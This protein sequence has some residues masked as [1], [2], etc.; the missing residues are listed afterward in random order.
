MRYLLRS[1][2]T[3]AAVDASLSPDA[4]QRLY[5]AAAGL[6]RLLGEANGGPIWKDLPDVVEAVG[7]LSETT[8]GGAK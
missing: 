6:E 7:K 4:V 2:E 5:R 3:T 8:E 1:P